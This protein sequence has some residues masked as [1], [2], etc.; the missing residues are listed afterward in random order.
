MNTIIR[1]VCGLLIVYLVLTVLAGGPVAG[2]HL[3]N[4]WMD[5]V[6]VWVAKWD[7]GHPAH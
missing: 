4:H 3:L 2:L 7:T 5:N 1:F 6:K